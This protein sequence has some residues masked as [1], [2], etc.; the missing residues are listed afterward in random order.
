M[1]GI[2]EL[3]ARYYWPSS[4]VRLRVVS[5]E[6]I[7]LDLASEEIF[8]LNATGTRLWQELAEH[9]DPGIALQ[10]LGA[11]FD[12][13]Q[14]VLRRDMAD[15]LEK[16]LEAGLISD[17]EPFESSTGENPGPSQRSS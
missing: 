12:V 7:L 2:S 10:A 11:E 17:K 8:R 4:N 6:A 13:V 1:S 14:D 9:H 16:L 15:L 5:G 3:L